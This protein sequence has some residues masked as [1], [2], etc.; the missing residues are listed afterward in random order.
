MA[1]EH[2]LQ[3]QFGRHLVE[4]RTR[5]RVSQEKL[6]YES[7]VSRSYLSGIER[8]VRNVS[9]TKIVLL[10]RT[11]GLEPAELMRFPMEEMPKA[12]AKQ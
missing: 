3:V 5:Q 2:D 9:L 8:G 6:A 7:G 10:A 1:Q 4:L 12:A 11:L